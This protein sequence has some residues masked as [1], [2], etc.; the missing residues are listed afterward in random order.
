MSHKFFVACFII[1]GDSLMHCGPE[2][3]SFGSEL[4]LVLGLPSWLDCKLREDRGPGWLL[5]FHHESG[6]Y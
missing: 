6:W 2:G 3:E 1:Y 5:S 4:Y